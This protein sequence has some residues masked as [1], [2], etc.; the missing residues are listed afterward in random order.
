MS[1]DSFIDKVG[2]A[3][4]R[5]ADSVATDVNVAAQEQKIR[6]AYRALG[7]LYYQAV[8]AGTAPEGEAFDVQLD[9]IRAGLEEINRLRSGN[10]V[11]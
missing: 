2:A 3:A 10:R 5:A 9:A 1:F 8:Q 7:K 4:K 6:D 11:D